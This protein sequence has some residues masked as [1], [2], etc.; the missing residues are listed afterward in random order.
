MF[1]YDGHVL[2]G[3]IA[4]ALLIPDLDRLAGHFTARA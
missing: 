4:D 3:L 1:S 2:V